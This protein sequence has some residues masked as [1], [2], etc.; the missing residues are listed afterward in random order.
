MHLFYTTS[1]GTFKWRLD[2][3]HLALLQHFVSLVLLYKTRDLLTYLG[4]MFLLDPF[5]CYAD[6]LWWAARCLFIENT[7]RMC[8]GEFRHVQHVRPNRGPHK[9][10]KKLSVM[11]ISRPIT[12][13]LPH[14]LTVCSRKAGLKLPVSCCCNSSVHCSTGPQQTVDDD[15][16]ACRVKAV[17]GWGGYGVFIY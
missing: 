4:T 3:H 1:L 12:P 7:I 5:W 11:H 2:E 14:S 17:G 16:C 10:T 6:M 8:R 9:K 15:Y 13:I